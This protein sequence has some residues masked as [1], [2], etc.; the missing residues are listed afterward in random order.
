[1]KEKTT[2]DV[3]I[4]DLGMSTNTS[5]LLGNASNKRRSE[6][7]TIAMVQ[8]NNG[9]VI[10]IRPTEARK[11]CSRLS[12]RRPRSPRS[13]H[14]RRTRRPTSSPRPWRYLEVLE[15]TARHLRKA[16][17]FAA[18][19]GPG[20]SFV[21]LSHRHLPGCQL[22]T[23]LVSLCAAR[24]WWSGRFPW[25]DGRGGPCM[26]PACFGDQ[27]GIEWISRLFSSSF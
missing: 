18:R 11:K 17:G 22:Q 15:V 16:M 10:T 25:V 13:R 20:A 3:K 26:M 23:S 4:D 12:I 9:V 6:V 2:A 8:S 21:T 27:R 24:V 19:H 7:M 14:S 1:M 5:W